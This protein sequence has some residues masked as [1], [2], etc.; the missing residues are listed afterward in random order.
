MT[1]KS[2]FKLKELNRK[3]KHELQETCNALDA[4]TQKIKA[5]ESE[6]NETKEQLRINNTLPGLRREIVFV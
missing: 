2:L 6:L 5:L 1:N 3:L 4:E